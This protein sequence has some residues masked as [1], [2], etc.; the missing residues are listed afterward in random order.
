MFS[1]WQKQNAVTTTKEC[2][3]CGR[4][5]ERGD[6]ELCMSCGAYHCTECPSQHD[7]RCCGVAM[8]NKRAAE[9]ELA[10]ILAMEE[11]V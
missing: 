11:A 5:A 6:L 2:V 4:E 3:Y 8:E 9:I 10:A 7:W 1:F